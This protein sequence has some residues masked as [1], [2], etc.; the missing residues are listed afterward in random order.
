MCAPRKNTAHRRSGGGGDDGLAEGERDARERASFVAQYRRQKGKSNKVNTVC[1]QMAARREAMT[2]IVASRTRDCALAKNAVSGGKQMGGCLFVAQL[3]AA[4]K[5]AIDQQ[6]F[7]VL[8]LE[9][10]SGRC[11]CASFLDFPCGRAIAK[12]A[13]DIQRHHQKSQA[14]VSQW[15]RDDP[16][17][18]ATAAASSAAAAAAA[19]HAVE[20]N[21]SPRLHWP[22]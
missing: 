11:C 13:D 16:R 14:L 20:P 3:V 21:K 15:T 12:R 6:G 8:W 2:I 4:R 17:A 10:A 1:S 5:K 18:A 22:L 9:G 7:V 19:D